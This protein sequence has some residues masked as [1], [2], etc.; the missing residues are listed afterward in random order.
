MPM[1]IAAMTATTTYI[2]PILR[3]KSF[4]CWASK[5]EKGK[6]EKANVVNTFF[7]AFNMAISLGCF[8]SKN[9]R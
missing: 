1:K 2:L 3:M 8:L 9:G 6:R 5:N 7:T 4:S